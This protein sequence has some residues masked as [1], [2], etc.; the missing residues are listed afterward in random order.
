MGFL[1]DDNNQMTVYLTELGIEKFFN[2]GFKDAIR[3]FS[4][5]DD[6][7]YEVFNPIPETIPPFETNPIIDYDL[8]SKVVY[9]GKFYVLMTTGL[10]APFDTPDVVTDSWARI[11][12]YD[13]TILTKQSL[14]A[15]THGD[16]ID[17]LKTNVLGTN[18]IEVVYGSE[19]TTQTE[20]RG[21]QLNDK[22]TK[23]LSRGLLSTKNNTARNYVMYEPDFNSNDTI[24]L[25][26][27]INE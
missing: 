15:I 14:G 19:I 11:R 12:P 3:Y 25:L 27:Y 21:V 22:G 7:N 23:A 13:P 20:L 26:T 17:A 5:I 1:T 24:S 18:D 9:G 8:G 4:I 2:G 16:E 6:A 10:T